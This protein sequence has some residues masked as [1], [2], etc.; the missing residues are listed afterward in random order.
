MNA[1]MERERIEREGGDLVPADHARQTTPMQILAAAIERGV[2][3]AQLEKLMDLQERYEQNE[4]RKEFYKARASFAA[5][6]PTIVKDKT[7]AQY[8]SRYSSLENF[9]NAVVAGLSPHG[10][11]ANWTVDQ[12]AGISVTCVLTHERGHSESVTI[13]GPPDT[14]GKKNDLQQIKSTLTYLKL[15]TLEAITGIASVVGNV[16]D[17]GN[18][19]GA[20]PNPDD[21]PANEHQLATIKEYRDAEKI[22][23]VTLAWLDKQEA[24]TVKQAASLINKLK[25]ASK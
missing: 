19:A 14:S 12:S 21:E 13:S 22:P 18:G 3:T 9:V 8:G 1:V 25:G 20:K 15:A 5:N 4:A 10:L 23:D 17:D 7:N 6:P 11:S 24:L 2:D 16:D